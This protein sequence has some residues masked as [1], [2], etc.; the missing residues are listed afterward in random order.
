[1][2]YEHSLEDQNVM[3]L[4]GKYQSLRHFFHRREK[5]ILDFVFKCI[6]CINTILPEIMCMSVVRCHW[7][8]FIYKEWWKHVYSLWSICGNKKVLKKVLSWINIWNITV[9]FAYYLNRKNMRMNISFKKEENS[10][11]QRMPNIHKC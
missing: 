3:M 10:I 2:C 6:F 11:P 7:K 4:N 8:L 1:M 9:I 5:I